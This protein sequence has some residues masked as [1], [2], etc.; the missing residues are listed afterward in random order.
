MWVNKLILFV[1]F[2]SVN[3]STIRSIEEVDVDELAYEIDLWASTNGTTV[4]FEEMIEHLR[5][6]TEIH[7]SDWRTFSQ[8]ADIAMCAICR[9]TAKL[10]MDLR[11]KGMTAEEIQKQITK[12]CVLLN[13]QKERVCK[14]VIE[15]NI[16][17]VLYIVDTKPNLTADTICGVI[18]ES[19]S[20][21]L[22]NPEF[23]WSIVI[24]NSSAIEIAENEAEEP[25]KILQLTDF[26]YDPAYEPR[27]NAQ[28]GEPLC[29]RKGQ[30]NTN[31]K[32]LAGYWGDYNSCDTPWHAIVD[33]LTHINDTHR[34]INYVYFTGDVI[35]HGVWETS[36][37]GNTKSL[38][39][40]YK[41]IY[42]TFGNIPVYPILGNHEPHPLNQFAPKNIT[43]DDITT[44]WLYELVADL[45]IGYGWLPESTRGTIHHG[46]YYTV[47]PTKG[48]RVI[49]L[50]SNICYSYNWWLWYTPRD[51]DNQLQW[52]ADTLRKA[53]ENQEFVH[54]L[55][56]IPV[57]TNAC[58]KT[59][60][61]EYIKI[62]NRYSH[63]IKAE[64]N[65]HSHNDEV[66][67][68]Y[69][70]NS[71]AQNIAWN[72]GSI[73]GFSK[74]NPNYK[75][76]NVNGSNYAVND[77]QNWMYDIGSANKDVNKRPKWF[78]SYSFKAEYGLPELSAGSLNNWLHAALNNET[79]VNKYYNNFFKH[80]E[81]SLKENCNL[82]CKKQ[83]LNRI[84]INPIPDN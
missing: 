25:L 23:E 3:S 51:P 29:C 10:Y 56:H 18:F 2:L 12:L 4:L 38:V 50:N 27:G 48:F 71:E 14:G 31:V 68:F 81:P 11:R 7:N 73:T 28:C 53:E 40:I 70:S 82:D 79:L 72:G 36:R 26:H 42:E 13:V 15:L 66:A 33:A 6:P 22:A 55:S 5:I 54:I 46:G 34:D 19:K 8:G 21:P 58:L 1:L 60:K 83:Y 47:S 45:W 32:S 77:Y 24:D 52:L 35:D 62:I 20:C 43:L 69:N 78:K 17:T 84:I 63:I 64:F 37:E 75:V 49:A 67:I 80:A 44:N 76:Y 16:P 61:R 57:N 59:W 41:K 9:A 74:L 39:K 30:N 65:G